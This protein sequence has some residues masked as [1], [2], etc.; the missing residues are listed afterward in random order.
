VS[1]INFLL[2]FFISQIDTKKA[3]THNIFEPFS[4]IEKTNF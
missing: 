3:Q 1:F 2:S 4:N